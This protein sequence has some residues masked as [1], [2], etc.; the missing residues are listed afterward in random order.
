MSDNIKTIKS[1]QI[2]SNLANTIS[3]NKDINIENYSFDSAPTNTSSNYNINDFGND[4]LDVL[5]RTGATVVVGAGKVLS[6]VQDVGEHMGDGL[7]YAGGKIIEGES[8]VTSQIVGIVNK[9]YQNRILDWREKFKDNVKDA[10]SIDVI[11]NLENDVY[12][13]TPL[14]SVND[15]S[16]LK[17]DSKVANRIESIS[18]IVGELAVATGTLIASGGTA[19]PMS[20]NLIVNGSLGLAEG[21]GIQASD[22]YKQNKDITGAEEAGIVLSGVAGSARWIAAGI[23]GS[24]TVEALGSIRSIYSIRPS[25]SELGQSIREALTIHKQ[26]RAARY[27][28]TAVAG[29]RHTA[30]VIDTIGSAANTISDSIANGDSRLRTS[31]KVAIGATFNILMNGAFDMIGYRVDNSRITGFAGDT[32]SAVEEQL[33][34]TF[35]DIVENV[36]SGLDSGFY[37]TRFIDKVVDNVSD[38]AASGLEE[39]RNSFVGRND[40]E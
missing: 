38:R 40:K 20:I 9:E 18:S 15:N 37:E 16:Y 27:I 14:K 7:L 36:D 13:N 24:K 23:F 3:I 39:L 2:P 1:E 32:I 22:T 12:N 31:T 6:G 11:D 28:S 8:Y 4:A 34:P 19:A 30:N 35:G 17:Y 26:K 29:S 25:F 33:I 21:I 10:I 5:K